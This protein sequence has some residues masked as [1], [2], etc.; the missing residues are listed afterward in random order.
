MNEGGA[1]INRSN[2][3]KI[4]SEFGIENLNAALKT[5]H[6]N[7][8]SIQEFYDDDKD[9]KQTIDLYFE[10][11]EKYINNFKKPH[12]E[13]AAKKEKITTPTS[14]AK[15]NTEKKMSSDK[16]PLKTESKAK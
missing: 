2:Y 9:I 7:Y 15:L 11:I 3:D 12:S 4:I 5:Q 14:K 16:Q 10:T 1:M 6:E 13:R 8:L